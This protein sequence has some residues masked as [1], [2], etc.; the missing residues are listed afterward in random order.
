MRKLLFLVMISL[1]PALAAAQQTPKLEVL[2]G[3]SNLT[4]NLS[5]SSFSLNGLVVS[6]TENISSWFGGT[7][8]FSTHFGTENGFKVNTMSLAYG[9]VFAY[10]KNKRIVPFAHTLL[11]AV[12][13]GAEYLDISKPEYRFGI[14]AG[15][16][17]DVRLAPHV[18]LRLVQAD[19][20]MTR[21]SNARQDS[22]RLSA[23]LVLRWGKK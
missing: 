7:L 18:A 22:L 17:V 16:G 15:G 2:G 19:Y 6:A 3:Y 14:Y 1:L 10:R 5:A 11:G 4:A 23:G 9:P 20:L 12:R 21:F 13:G 8:D